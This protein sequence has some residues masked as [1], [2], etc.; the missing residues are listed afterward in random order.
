[1]NN[2]A[3]RSRLEIVE[4]NAVTD[5]ALRD[6]IAGHMAE[7]SPIP[8]AA[9]ALRQLERAQR[10]LDAARANREAAL[11]VESRWRDLCRVPEEIL[12]EIRVLE[13]KRAYYISKLPGLR[14]RYEHLLL[15][16]GSSVH[17]SQQEF[18]QIQALESSVQD[19]LPR[20]LATREK[21]LEKAIVDV[22]AF[23]KEHRIPPESVPTFERKPPAPIVAQIDHYEAEAQ[24]LD[25]AKRLEEAKRA[26]TAALS[27]ATEARNIAD[28]KRRKLFPDAAAAEQEANRLAEVAAAAAENVKAI[29][30]ES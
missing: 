5:A 6:K 1:M 30:A 10:D 20:M 7:D 13:S 24:A 29:E 16:A 9:E 22:G 14:S 15:S 27:A 26:R 2:S 11:G 12:A 18:L 25:R 8:A 23:A 3:A 21:S 17:A 4:A 19:T 28:Q